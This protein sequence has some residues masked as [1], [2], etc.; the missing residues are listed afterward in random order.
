MMLTRI[1]SLLDRLSE[2]I[3]RRKGLLPLIGILFILV[4]FTIQFIPWFG[5]FSESNLLL[6]LGLVISIIG[7]L[8]A[9]AL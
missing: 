4:N 2:F 3:A 8:L 9:W 1:S 6:H 7:F 5:W